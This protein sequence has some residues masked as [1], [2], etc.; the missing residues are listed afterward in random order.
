[1]GAVGGICY[2]DSLLCE[3]NSG[4]SKSVDIF[5]AITGNWT[6]ANLSEARWTLAAT[7][8]PNQGLAVFAGGRGTSCDCYCDDCWEAC[9]V[10][11]DSAHCGTAGGRPACVGGE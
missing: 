7:S 3:G 2:N 6:T 11:A 9:G 5:N 8:L 4:Y 10:K 1:M